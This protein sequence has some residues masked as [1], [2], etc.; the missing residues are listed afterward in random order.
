TYDGAW[1]IAGHAHTNEELVALARAQL[2]G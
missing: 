1:G 2:S